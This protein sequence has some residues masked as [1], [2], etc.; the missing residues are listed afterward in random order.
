MDMNKKLVDLFEYNKENQFF[1]LGIRPWGFINFRCEFENLKFWPPDKKKQTRQMYVHE[2]YHSTRL[3]S[4][5]S[6][7]SAYN[8][9]L[10]CALAEHDEGNLLSCP[11]TSSVAIQVVGFGTAA[12]WWSW[13]V[14][15]S[16]RHEGEREW[17]SCSKAMHIIPSHQLLFI[18]FFR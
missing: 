3:F 18:L 16:V 6:S 4:T 15:R 9:R 2:R 12:I 14:G 13:T 5:F 17:S 11:L 1:M 10:S 7:S 8:Q